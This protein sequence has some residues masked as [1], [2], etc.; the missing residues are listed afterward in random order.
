VG[1][2]A[3]RHVDHPRIARRPLQVWLQAQHESLLELEELDTFT[4]ECGAGG[5][6]WIAL[7]PQKG[8][9]DRRPGWVEDERRR[10]LTA[11]SRN[12]DTIC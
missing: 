7:N 11:A 4:A 5:P 2:L 9:I 1:P 12:E 10:R 8:N 3:A 6:T